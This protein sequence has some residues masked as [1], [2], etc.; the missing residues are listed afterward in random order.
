MTALS[1]KGRFRY[2]GQALI[3]ELGMYYYKAC[4]YSP[5][6]GRFLQTDPIGYGDGMNMYNY[7]GGDPMNMVDPTGM[8]RM[9]TTTNFYD[10]NGN[11]KPDPG[12]PVNWESKTP[13]GCGSGAGYEGSMIIYVVRDADGG[14]NGRR[15]RNRSISYSINVPQ[16]EHSC[17]SAAQLGAMASNVNLMLEGS[18]ALLG[19]GA[20]ASSPTGVGGGAL[21]MGAFVAAAGSKGASVVSIGAYGY[22]FLTTGNSSSLMGVGSGFASLF[23]SGIATKVTGNVMRSGRMFRNLSAPQQARHT[24]ADAIYGTAAGM[25]ENLLIDTGC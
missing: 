16:K 25:V 7:V 1:T 19:I 6:L 18:S 5:T 8:C 12:E 23:V 13:I 20:I 15:N 2:T 14:G 22:D 10:N 21:G 3:P 17:S 9:E 24:A 4:I 11:G